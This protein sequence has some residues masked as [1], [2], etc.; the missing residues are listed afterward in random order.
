MS[1][2]CVFQANKLQTRLQNITHSFLFS[3]LIGEA[4]HF[5]LLVTRLDDPGNF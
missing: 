3:V 1:S 5:L 4:E 2:A